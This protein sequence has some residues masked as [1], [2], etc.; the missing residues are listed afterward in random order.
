LQDMEPRE[1]GS[2]LRHPAAG[3]KVASCVG[4]FPYLQASATLLQASSS[5]DATHSFH[6]GMS[7][8]TT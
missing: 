1:I 8:P 6:R 5:F 2:V 4:S 7:A 3:D